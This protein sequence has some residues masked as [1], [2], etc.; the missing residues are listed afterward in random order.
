MNNMICDFSDMDDFNTAVVAKTAAKVV[1]L[2]ACPKCSGHGHVQFGYS[3]GMCYQCQGSGKVRADWIARRAQAQKASATRV[4][5]TKK[6]GEDF[7]KS[8]PDVMEWLE[9]ASMSFEFANSLRDW[10]HRKGGL[11]DGQ[12]SAVRKCIAGEA[13]RAEK[14]KA[15]AESRSV[16][17]GDNALAIKVSL[18]KAA[19]TGLGRPTIRTE[20]LMFSRAG[21][22]SRNPGCV[23]VTDKGETYLG[24]I[25]PTGKF[26]PSR[27]CTDEYRDVVF[28][29]AAD[30]LA[31]AVSFGRMSGTCSCCGRR[32]DNKESVELGIGPI[33]RSKFF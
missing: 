3:S 16:A 11:T 10:H 24:K 1:T 18:D 19:S 31:A 4:M 27:D 17:L 9:K 15:T 7:A 28:T 12:V 14:R 6:L 26:T 25:D 29:V 21:D 32:L 8:N 23:Y 5:N 33:C 13:D 20:K 2:V 22:A 30:P